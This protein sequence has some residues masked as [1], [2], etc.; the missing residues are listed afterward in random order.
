[1]HMNRW[2]AVSPGQIAWARWNDQFA[3]YHR[4]SGKTHFLNAAS[5]LLIEH[6]LLEP[7]D[8]ETAARMLSQ[9]TEGAYCDAAYVR[10]VADTIR[11]LEQIGLLEPA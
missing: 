5:V 2:R 3:V 11:R 10:H 4:P 7:G 8:V 6:I 9:H 1:M